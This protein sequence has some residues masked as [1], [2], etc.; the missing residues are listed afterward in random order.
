[1]IL[2]SNPGPRPV[3]TLSRAACSFGVRLPALHPLCRCQRRGWKNFLCW[4]VLRSAAH[5][6]RPPG[7][8]VVSWSHDVMT[9]KYLVTPSVSGFIMTGG[10]CPDNEQCVKTEVTV[11]G[12]RLVVD[13]YFSRL[14]MSNVWR[15]HGEFTCVGGRAKLSRDN[16]VIF[17]LILICS[18]P[19]PLQGIRVLRVIYGI[20]KIFQE[21]LQSETN[22]KLDLMVALNEILL[23]DNIQ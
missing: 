1:M 11:P 19:G 9:N 12:P 21:I 20:N 10:N 13:V 22:A 17:L 18:G 6:V 7:D 8:G 14:I 2:A 3:K 15:K 4:I 16:I 5:V 23:I